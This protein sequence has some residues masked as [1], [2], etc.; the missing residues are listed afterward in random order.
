MS[1]AWNGLPEN[2]ERD[3]WHWII[4]GGVMQAPWLWSSSS[5]VWAHD[6][7][8][9]K[10]EDVYPGFIYLGPC[11]PPAEVAALRAEVARMRDGIGKALDEIADA[12]PK[13]LK[14]AEQEL[15]AALASEPRA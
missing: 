10:P 15:R 3:G 1:E 14:Y 13:A 11:L 8:P 2:P 4:F 12:G 6:S 9:W 7:G 5:Q